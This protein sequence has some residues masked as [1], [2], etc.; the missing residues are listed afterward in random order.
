VLFSWDNGSDFAKNE[1][2]AGLKL[3]K[4]H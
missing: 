1:M 4:G 3:S 2:F